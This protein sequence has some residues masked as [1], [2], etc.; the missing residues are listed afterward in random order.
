MRRRYL[1]TETSG[2]VRQ[3]SLCRQP[4]AQQIRA[5]VQARSH[6]LAEILRR[7]MRNWENRTELKKQNNLNQ[8]QNETTPRP[9]G[10]Q[11]TTGFT[12]VQYGFLFELYTGKQ[13]NYSFFVLFKEVP[14]E[15]FPSIKLPPLV[16][17]E[18]SNGV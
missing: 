15:L 7:K 9:P 11:W 17:R 1:T 8:S 13:H 6:L 5:L 10:K 3:A 16:K 14:S 12:T 4:I 18:M 2:D